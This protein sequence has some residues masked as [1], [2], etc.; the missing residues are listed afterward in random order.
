MDPPLAPTVRGP[1][2]PPAPPSDHWCRGL[3]V[4]LGE[5]EA[6]KP[7]KVGGCRW[8]GWGAEPA[9]RRPVPKHPPTDLVPWG[10]GPGKRGKGRG[11]GGGGPS[12]AQPCDLRWGVPS[13]GQR[14]CACFV[15][16]HSKAKVLGEESKWPHDLRRLGAPPPAPM[17]AWVMH[18]STNYAAGVCAQGQT[19]LHCSCAT[20][21]SRQGWGPKAS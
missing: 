11:G 1:G 3:G 12:T 18:I 20:R 7:Q 17:R 5:S 13:G 6:W 10:A 9:P 19:P 16:P 4:S 21:C 15:M 14:M 8:T 2:C